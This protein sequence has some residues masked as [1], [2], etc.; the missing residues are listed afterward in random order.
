LFFTG[1]SSLPAQATK[2]DIVEISKEVLKLIKS[3]DFIGLSG[4]VHKSKGL[5]FCT[6]DQEYEGGPDTTRF[7]KRNVKNFMTIKRRYV[8]GL[9]DGSGSEIKFTPKEYYKKFIYDIDYEKIADVVFIG[10]ANSK[11]PKKININLVYIFSL[12]PNATIAHYFYRG[13]LEYG[14]SDY[15]QLTLVFERIERNWF[16]TGILHGERGT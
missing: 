6:S 15:K 9:Y 10:D 13:S 2:D 3:A 12:Y 1:C 5:T 11:R 14:Y 7:S 16:L 8:W 4:Y